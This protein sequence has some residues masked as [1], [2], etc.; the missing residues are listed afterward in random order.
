MCFAFI[1]VEEDARAAVQ[2]GDDYPLGTIDD[3][4][5][6]LG[7]ERNFAHV[8]FLF[9][10]VF[11]GAGSCFTVVQNHTKLDTQRRGVGHSTDL[12][13]F[14][15]KYRL[16]QAIA[17]ILKLSTTGVTGDRENATESGL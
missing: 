2:L 5:A 13:F 16:T 14:Y 3:K 10:D 17:D 6:V 9:L 1:V 15:V 4:G 7:H 8:Y 12:A 11:D